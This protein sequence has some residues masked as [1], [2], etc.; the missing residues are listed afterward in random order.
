MNPQSNAVRAGISR[1]WI[2]F[3]ASF[4][5][6]QEVVVGYMMMPVIFLGLGLIIGDGS[7][8]MG[9]DFSA[10]M[11]V[12]GVSLVIAING[13][14]TVAQVLA[15]E[16]EDGTLLR[17]K[18]TPHGMTGYVVA[19]VGHI[20][21]MSAFS[22]LLLLVPAVFLFDGFSPQ[23]IFGMVTLLWVC[24]LGLLALAPV[25]AILGSLITNPKN[26]V[27]LAMLPVIILF[28]ISGVNIPLEFMPGWVQVIALT[29][30]IYWVGHGVR[31]AVFPPEA[32]D[33]EL[34][35]VWQLPLA[36]GVLA[37]WALVGFLVA[38]PLLQRM[39]RRT[40]GSRVQAAREEAAKR[41]Y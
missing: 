6:P 13:V 36:A 33:L 1:S 38:R 31:A 9:V 14:A 35:G 19:K 4:T 17:A 12:G 16:R 28:M 32:T 11:L 24:L 27:G 8:E 23:G 30:P 7:D 25:G 15:T 39:A 2:E 40:S 41:A 26:G 3:R 18:S 22:L 37:L 5:N 21:M 29:F 34:F 10:A 20:V